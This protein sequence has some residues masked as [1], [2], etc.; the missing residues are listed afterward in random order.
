MQGYHDSPH[1]YTRW[2]KAGVEKLFDDFEMI[3]LGI[4]SGPTSSFLWVLQEWLATLFS[5]NISFLYK[6][7]FAFFMV[8]TCPLKW[9]D[10]VLNRYKSAVNIASNFYFFGKKV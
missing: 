10:L 9:L 2:T 7:L 8:L 3:E 1:D 5:F 6:F 4:G